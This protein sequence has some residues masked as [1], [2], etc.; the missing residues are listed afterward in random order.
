MSGNSHHVRSRQPEVS[1]QWHCHCS[2]A[3]NDVFLKWW[4]QVPKKGN[5]C[6]LTNRFSLF[7]HWVTSWIECHLFKLTS[8]DRV[9]LTFTYSS[10]GDSG[11]SRFV[12]GGA[13]QSQ[14]AVAVRPVLAAAGL[15]L[16]PGAL[17][18]ASA[19]ILG[20]CPTTFADKR[21]FKGTSPEVTRRAFVSRERTHEKEDIQ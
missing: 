2:R 9:P 12:Y 10:F 7:S 4:L 11:G 17:I 3:L 6:T 21:G 18:T 5:G 15:P 16:Q 1:K 20:H 8:H 13:G 19:R 14:G